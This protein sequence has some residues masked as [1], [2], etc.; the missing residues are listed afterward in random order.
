MRAASIAAQ[1][2]WHGNEAAAGFFSLVAQELSPASSQKSA[3]QPR[4]LWLTGATASRLT[5][6]GLGSRSA[7][8]PTIPAKASTRRSPIFCQTLLPAGAVRSGVASLAVIAEGIVA[9]SPILLSVTACRVPLGLIEIASAIL[10]LAKTSAVLLSH[11]RT[12][13]LIEVRLVGAARLLTITLGRISP[14][15]LELRLIKLLV[16]IRGSKVGVAGVA[17]E[18]VGSVVVGI[19]VVAVDV[20]GVDVVA[21]DVSGIDVIDVTVVVVIS[22]DEGV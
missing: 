13:L 5:R 20:G 10:I 17:V 6:L 2:L 15:V 14:V 8:A 16:E 3:P 21:V 1:R 4:P 22:I 11:P 19:N 7:A 18:I 12:I 9:G